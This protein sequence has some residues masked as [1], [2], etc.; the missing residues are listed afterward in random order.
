MDIIVGFDALESSLAFREYCYDL[1]YTVRVTSLVCH[2]RGK[3]IGSFHL[4]VKDVD[5]EEKEHLLAGPGIVFTCE[6]PVPLNNP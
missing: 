3:E 4:I 5:A 6:I 2:D 1:G